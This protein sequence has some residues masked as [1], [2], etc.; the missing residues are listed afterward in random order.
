MMMVLVDNFSV[1]SRNIQARCG[2]EENQ[3]VQDGIVDKTFVQ[4]TLDVEKNS[5]TEEEDHDVRAYYF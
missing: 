1:Q 3:L 2:D 5:E 4:H